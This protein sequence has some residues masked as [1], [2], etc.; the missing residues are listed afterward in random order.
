MLLTL[1]EGFA[2]SASMLLLLFSHL[3][4]FFLRA[5]SLVLSRAASLLTGYAL[6]RSLTQPNSLSFSYAD[7]FKIFISCPELDWAWNIRIQLSPPIYPTGFINFTCPKLNYINPFISHLH[8]LSFCIHCL[9]SATASVYASKLKPRVNLSSH[10]LIIK[11]VISASGIAL[12]SVFSSPFL[13]LL[14]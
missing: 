14:L 9:L 13:F 2:S 5:S 12:T 3:F 6:P 10:N 4:P 1:L 11:C 7:V 8:L